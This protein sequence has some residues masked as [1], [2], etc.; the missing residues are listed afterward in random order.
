[1]IRLIVDDD[2]RGIDPATRAE[3]E[4]TATSGSGCF[5]PSPRISAGRS[6]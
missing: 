5:A 2:G 3:R 4:V 6:T 1:M